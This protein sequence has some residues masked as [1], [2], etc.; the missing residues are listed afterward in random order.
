MKPM[1]V[2]L[3]VLLLA[4]VGIGTGFAACP[5]GQIEVQTGVCVIDGAAVPKYVTPLVIP[6]VM[7]KGAEGE[8]GEDGGTAD[9]YDIA[10]RQFRQQIL[11]GGIWNAL[12]GRTDAYPP[13]T[14][15]SYGPTADPLP[16]ASGLGV[17]AGVAP[18]PN[19]QFNYPAYTVETRSNK[20]VNVRWRNELKDDF[21]A[22]PNFLPHLLPVDQTLHWANPPGGDAGKDM[23]GTDP[24]PYTGPV[25]I[26]THVHGAH[27]DPHSDGYPEAWWLP[28]GDVPAGYAT[29][30][31]FFDDATGTNPGN[32]GYAD[33]SYRQDQPATTLWYHDHTLGMTRSNVYAG[34][35]GFWLIRGGENDKAD[36]IRTRFLRWDGILPGPASKSGD[37]VLELNAPGVLGARDKRRHIREIPIAIQDRSFKADGSLFYPDNRA[38]FEGLTDPSAL[39]IDF[40]PVSD[41]APIWNPEAFFNVMV[42]NGTTW[43]TLDVAP[44][45]YRFRLLNGCN[46]RFLNLSLKVVSSP[47]PALVGK[48]LS[49]YQIGAEQGFLPKVVEV[50]T[51]FATPLPGDGRIPN[52]ANRVAAADPDQA[53]LMALAERAD[54]LVDFRWLPPGTV[55]RMINTGPDE[56]FGGFTG[57][58]PGDEPVSDP[59]TTGQVMQF[60][61]KWKLLN[62]RD[63]FTTAPWALKL[64]AEPQLGPA[65]NAGNPRKVSLNEVDSGVVCVKADADGAFVVPIVQVACDPNDPTVVPF[66]P[67]QALLGVVDPGTGLGVPLKWNDTTG[68][69]TPVAVTLQSGAVMTV[70]VTENPTLGDTED[71]EISN[72]TADAHPIHLHLVRF[73]VVGRAPF[74]QAVVEGV[75]VEPWETGFK[76]TVIS[77]PGQITKVRAKFDIEGLYVWHCHIVEHEDNEMMRPYVVSR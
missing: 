58:G 40:A 30:G 33:F 14:V 57:A 50:R 70:N 47:N 37:T 29:K 74:G 53:L 1:K 71:W 4:T 35:A 10:V 16:D 25:P 73:Q 62:F 5:D 3:A 23:E 59:A 15:W 48:E 69:S 52:P 26:V 76:D 38:F 32:L 64:N 66:G 54:V 11:P 55:I 28:A 31:T 20:R 72:F 67:E 51:G 22:G 27:V 42:V 65:V 7:K 45:L 49:F 68:T 2:G 19:S 17:S 46:S 21:G 41:I 34:P 61:V 44:A 18:A 43:P 9:N 12:N 75:G 8:E 77:Y 6:P 24:T 13:T 39:G 60:V 36:N 56:P 63:I